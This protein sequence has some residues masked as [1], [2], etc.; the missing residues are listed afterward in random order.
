[1]ILI[2]DNFK[3]YLKNNTYVALGSF[4]GLHMGHMKLIDKT[5]KLAKK[6]NAK[7]MVFTF[8]NHP[9]MVINKELAPRIIMD[10]PSKI[11]ILQSAGLDIVNMASFDKDFM[12]ITPEEFIVNLVEHYNVKGI[13]V[14]FNYRFGYKNLGDLSLLKKM[15]RKYNY[16][17]Q[18]V[19][20]VKLKGQVVSSSTIRNVISEE[21][22]MKKARK[23][24]TRP[25]MVGGNIIRGKQLGR[26]LGFPTVNLNYDKRFILPRG[27]VYYTIVYY[28]NKPYKGITNVGYNPTVEDNRLSVETNILNFHENIYNQYVS[29]F[30]IDRI[31]DEKKFDSLDELADQ[32]KKDKMYA[33]KQKLQINFKI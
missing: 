21:G 32:L 2:E 24:L 7:S 31:R 12:K 26:K 29:I 16:L 20:P 22:N 1:M 18:I 33:S 30:F 6:N 28:K 17:L 4:D 27:G 8:K 15:S 25:F 14:G 11:R 10:N 23:M 5:I 13:V 9:R 3:K 19:D